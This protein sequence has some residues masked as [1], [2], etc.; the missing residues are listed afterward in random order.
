MKTKR[1]ILGAACATAFTALV[2]CV[3]VVWYKQGCG[4]Y[5]LLAAI[6][7]YGSCGAAVWEVFDAAIKGE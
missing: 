5:S 3:C 6:A 2:A 7:F 1:I 4:L